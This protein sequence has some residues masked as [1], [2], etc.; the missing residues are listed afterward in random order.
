MYPR[1]RL[2]S[3]QS[4]SFAGKM[5]E[6]RIFGAI[7]CLVILSSWLYSCSKLT[8]LNVFAVNSLNIVG[9][10]S[11]I[12][13]AIQDIVEN[14]L[15]GNYLY[16]FSRSNIYL[17]PKNRIINDLKNN[18]PRIDNVVISRDHLNNLTIS[19]I[20][21]APVA[22]ACISLPDFSDNQ[23][24]DSSDSCY[25]VDQN[26]LIIK[27]AP[28][29]GSIYKNYYVPDL[30]NGTSSQISPI[31]LLATSTSEFLDLQNNVKL[32]EKNGLVV[33]GIL[34]KPSSEYEFYVNFPNQTGSSS[35]GA[36]DGDLVVIYM[37]RSEDLA[38]QVSNLITF[39]NQM[40]SQARMKNQSLNFEYIDTRYGSNV[41]Y[42]LSK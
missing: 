28:I 1:S 24:L 30:L 39:W 9:A 17:Y 42:R 25:F 21:K 6:R 15:D 31:G 33:L 41:F 11:E 27:K 8:R 10:D 34:L 20:E 12:V 4:K 29:S 22:L 35:S 40:S 32:L 26:G 38:I 13:P 3:R 19:I 23:K 7:L 14:D 36:V 16:L 2:T 5:R 37:N 18:I